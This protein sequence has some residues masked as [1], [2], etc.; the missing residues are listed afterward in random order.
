M[1]QFSYHFISTMLHSIWQTALLLVVYYFIIVVNKK[2]S[3]LFKRNVLLGLTAAQLVTS[4]FTFIIISIQPSLGLLMALP[5]SLIQPLQSSFI[6]NNALAICCLYFS[7]V[8]L[9][10]S[11]SFFCWNRFKI[12]YTKSLIKPGL[13]IRFFTQ[14]KSNQFG[15]SKKVSIWYSKSIST[16]MTFGFFK[17]VI[18][19]PFALVNQLSLQQ[20]EALIIHELTHIYHNDYLLNR[21]LL[22]SECIYF[23]NPFIHIIAQQIK[24]EREKNCD[25]QVLQFNYGS[26]L[27]AETLL[28]TAQY[29]QYQLSLQ[30]AAVKD[31]KQLL[32]RI[33]FFS[34]NKNLD[35]KT[36]NNFITTI[37]GAAI[38]L[39]NIILPGLFIKNETILNALSPAIYKTINGEKTLQEFTV[40]ISASSYSNAQSAEPVAPI[41]NN[42]RT[43]RAT[44]KKIYKV[45]INSAPLPDDAI[46]NNY[47]LPVSNEEELVEGKEIIISDEGS[48]GK[49]LT[50]VYN[51]ILVDG[52]WTLHPL[53]LLKETKPNKPD[54]IKLAKDSLVKILPAIQ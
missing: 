3:P 15:I 36:G 43:K 4:F 2:S 30:L 19:L 38:L 47:T 39:I 16:P 9:R 20:T 12:N 31:K 6:E 45:Q 10:V 32:Q 54:S 44:K 27:Y 24:K 1:E 11:N 13:D 53:Y 14:T 5:R 48:D 28:Q 37:C 33:H 26:I 34:I 42:A 41:N 23:F 50:A 25:V 7:F 17:P 8:L 52:I 18:L 49:K 29:Q 35:F 22:I 21:F 40:N 51:A 46:E